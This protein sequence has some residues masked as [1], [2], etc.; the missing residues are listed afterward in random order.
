[1]KYQHANKRILVV[2]DDPSAR[3]ALGEMLRAA[4]FN[5]LLAENGRSAVRTLMANPVSVIVLDFRTRF[6]AED[7]RLKKSK[8]LSALTDVDPF[9]P[10]IL[11][12]DVGVELDHE[13]ALMADLVLKHPVE[14]SALFDGIETLLGE[15]LRE[16]VY[17]KSDYIAT[18]R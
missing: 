9:L 15:S 17:R 3:E 5:V 2:S 11:T 1:M 12:S 7:S 14:S 10:V 18:L 4:D 8:T 6:D 13:T 16:R